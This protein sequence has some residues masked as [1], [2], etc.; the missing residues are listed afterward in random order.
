MR[1]IRP[2]VVL[3][4]VAVAGCG[5]SSDPDDGSTA[6][7]PEVEIVD[8]SFAPADLS[9]AVGD[10][11]TFTNGDDATHTATGSGESPVDSPDLRAG[12][13][14]AVT[15]EAAGTYEYICKFHPFMAGTIEVEG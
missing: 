12:D 13:E 4:M 10:T 2:L 3:A 8:F 6:E 1:P 11:V 7:Q 9:V 5:S 14:Y 15:F